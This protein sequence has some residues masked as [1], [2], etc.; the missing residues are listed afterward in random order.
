MAAKMLE[1]A[2][3]QPDFLGVES[4]RDEVGMRSGLPS[5][6]GQTSTQ[7]GLESQFGA[8]RHPADWPGKMVFVVQNKDIQG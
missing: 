4:A 8:S 2:P 1:L 6:I 3:Q 5:R 7:L